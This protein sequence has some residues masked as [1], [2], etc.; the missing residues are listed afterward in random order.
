MASSATDPVLDSPRRRALTLIYQGVAAAYGHPAAD[1][2]DQRC[3][4]GH[5]LGDH[6][7]DQRGCSFCAC[8]VRDAA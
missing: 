7:T 4:C 3:E 6:H 5:M 8:A 1:E 2:P